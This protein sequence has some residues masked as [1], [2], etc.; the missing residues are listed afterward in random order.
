[1]PSAP[2]P[3]EPIETGFPGLALLQSRIFRDERGIFVKT[4]HAPTFEEL[5]LAFDPQ[6][7]FYSTSAQN[8]LRGMH[9]Q[10]PPADHAKLVY[11]LAGRALDV[12][13]DMRR[14]SPRFGQAYSCELGS[15]DGQSLFIP[16]GFAH[17]FLSLEEGTVMVYKTDT[18]HTPD[19]DAGILWNS[20][21]FPWPVD[22]PIVSTRDQGFKP[23][24][25]FSSPF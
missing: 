25:Y 7:E 21:E 6:E 18:V 8:V 13:L 3:I 24:S 5:G 22:D 1:M 11:C 2:K 16:R 9:F 4:F 17:G 19:C 20:F 12:V 15:Q 23:W 10:M 14:A